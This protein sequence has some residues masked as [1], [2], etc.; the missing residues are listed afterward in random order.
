MRPHLL[1]IGL[2]LLSASFAL[3]PF[4]LAPVGP[5]LH[6]TVVFP[7]SRVYRVYQSNPSNPNFALAANA[8]AIDGQLSYYTWNELSRNITQAVTA[9]LPPGFDYWPTTPVVA[10]QSLVVDF[11]ATAAHNPS[12][13]DVWMTTPD[14]LPTLPL[15]WNRMQFLARPNV[16]LANGHYT[17]PLQIPANRQGHHVLWIAWQRNDPAGEVFVSTSDVLVQPVRDECA[18]ALAVSDGHNGPFSTV[19]GSGGPPTASCQPGTGADVWFSYHANCSGALHADTCSSLGTFDS[20]VSIWSGTCGSLMEIGCNNDS[21]GLLSQA[22]AAVAEGN[23]YYIRVATRGGTPL[24]AFDLDVQVSNTGTMAMTQPSGCSGSV[25]LTLSVN[26]NPNLG[27][28]VTESL[29]GLNGGIAL[30]AWGFPLVTQP[31]DPVCPCLV[32]T[33]T[34]G[35]LVGTASGLTIPCQSSLIGPQV[36]VQGAELFPS[37]STCSIPVPNNL[38]DI[39]TVTIG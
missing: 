35:W 25:P 3:A 1:S 10:G 20:V 22:T 8:V 39:W 28:T 17:F 4:A 31:L 30:L 6:G 12:V 15:T 23:T 21:C 11:R 26:G 29:S 16:T 19:A 36:L 18:G 32:V 13:W 34:P 27:G 33:N 7:K 14:W 37:N 5:P 24:G 2:A 38:S 9:G